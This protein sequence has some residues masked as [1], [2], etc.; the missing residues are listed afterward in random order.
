MSS[1]PAPQNT[2]L[3]TAVLMPALFVFLWSTGF[4]GGK[5]GLPH[6]EP[7][8]F[9]AIRFAIVAA[10]LTLVA[11]LFRARWPRDWRQIAHLA[12]VGLLL[13]GFYLGGVFAAIHDGVEAGT[14]AL[15]VGIQPIVTAILAGP[16]LGERVT[17]RQWLGFLL[18]L[19]GVALVVEQKL[20][21]G[22]GTPFG[23]GLCVM[24]LFGITLGTLYQKRFCAAMDLRTGNAIQFAAAFAMTTV[25]AFAFETR[26]VHWT[27]EFIIALAWL[28]IVLSFGAITLLMVLIRQGAASRVASLFFLVPPSAALIAW[29]LFGETFGLV[30]IIGMVLVVIG[31][32]LV[33]LSPVRQ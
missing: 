17:R 32:A 12:V 25:L 16:V 9:L 8:T 26:V 21:L 23:M 6:A 13:H 31:V 33:N 18:G 20:G 28:V 2:T 1:A 29:P 11:L 5:L 4:I 19:C 30:A 27:P 15:I 7:M 14:S 3:T 10:G 24:A 22:L